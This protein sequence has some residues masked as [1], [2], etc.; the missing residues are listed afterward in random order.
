MKTVFRFELLVEA[1]LAD[2]NLAEPLMK[3]CYELLKMFS[4]SLATAKRNC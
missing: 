1:E 3:E 2:K 4:A